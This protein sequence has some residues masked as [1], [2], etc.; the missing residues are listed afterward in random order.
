M[1]K[2]TQNSNKLSKSA[3]NRVI[4]FLTILC[5]I[6]FLFIGNKIANNE[7]TMVAES[8]NST[9]H[10]SIVTEITGQEEVE[11]TFNEGSKGKSIFFKAK[12]TDGDLKDTVVNSVQNYDPFTPV[13]LKEIS[14]GDKILI[15]E[16]ETNGEKEWVFGEYIRSDALIWLCLIFFVLLLI[17]GKGKGFNT[18]LSLVFTCLAV[19]LMFIPAILSGQNI[20]FW[21]AITCFFIVASTLLIIYKADKMTLASALGCASGILVAYVI[22]FIVDNVI[23][24]TGLVDEQSTFLLFLREDNPLDLK[25]IVFSGI[26]IGAIGAIMDVSIS[27]SSALYEV[28]EKLKNPSFK[29][30]LKSGLNIGR[31]IM[32]TMSNT[33]ILAYIGSSLSM[34]LLLAAYNT[35]ILYL[36]N[37]EMIVTEILQALVGSFALLSAIPATSLICAVI[38][39]ENG[40]KFITSKFKKREVDITEKKDDNVEQSWDINDIKTRINNKD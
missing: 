9:F 20:Y 21:T 32:G 12:I 31:D 36:F 35:S 34:V 18:I 26:I 38:Y 5:S 1:S 22:T 17:F 40:R 24:L 16:D 11:Y 8:G 6:L 10:R 19:F 27:I 25:A 7:K 3:Q 28:K 23:H 4:Y 14:V 29:D 33:L 39:T 2:I 13:K 37:R 30:I 15:Y